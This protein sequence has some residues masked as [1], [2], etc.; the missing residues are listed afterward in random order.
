MS[1]AERGLL[2]LARRLSAIAA[3]HEPSATS[4]RAAVE[5]LLSACGSG[6]ALAGALLEAWRVARTDKRAALALAWAREHVKL[7]IIELLL[8]E[9]KADRLRTD[10][11][12]DAL[13]WAFL[14]GAEAAVHELS[15][16][17][18]DRVDALLALAERAR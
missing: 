15:G 6:G 4:L 18:T 17:P 10:L 7:A 5:I 13:A 14:V 8:R 11:P 16:S 1:D 12:I 3:E 2:A 9:A